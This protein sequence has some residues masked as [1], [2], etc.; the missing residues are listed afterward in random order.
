MYIAW[1]SFRNDK[2][3]SF[4]FFFHFLPSNTAPPKDKRITLHEE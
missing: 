1:A 3:T 4:L 2:P